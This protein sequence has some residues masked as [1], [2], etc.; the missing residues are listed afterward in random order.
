MT[1][2]RYIDALKASVEAGLAALP[3]A[4]DAIVASFHGMPQ[5]DA[6]ARR[7]LSLPLP[8]DRAAAR[9]GAGARADRRV[10][11]AVRPRQM[12]GP[13]DRRRRW[14]RWPGEGKSKVAVVAPG[15]SADCLET[16]EE[17]AIRGRESFVAAGGTDFAYL[18]CLNDSAPAIAMLRSILARELA[19]WVDA[20]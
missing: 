12:A 17:L 1:I 16:L 13:G 8:E 5:A 3:F 4:P 11:V 19:G 14:W 6:G 18:P 15:F 20:P 10:P 2:P 7:S 9:R